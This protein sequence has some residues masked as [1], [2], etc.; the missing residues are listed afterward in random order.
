MGNEER[1]MV[2]TRSNHLLVY[3][4]V[5]GVNSKL[6]PNTIRISYRLVQEL[7][8]VLCGQLNAP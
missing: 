7:M 2:V 3:R 5:S 4:S 1:R 8:G 6:K